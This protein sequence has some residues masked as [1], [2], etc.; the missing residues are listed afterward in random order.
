MFPTL[1]HEQ[2][3]RALN[4]LTPVAAIL[5][6]LFIGVCGI[7]SSFEFDRCYLN[8]SSKRSKWEKLVLGAFLFHLSLLFILWGYRT[9]A[10]VIW[11]L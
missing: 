10:Y 6:F 8:I 11:G 2:L 7:F 5:S 1:E 4:V 3:V 9:Y